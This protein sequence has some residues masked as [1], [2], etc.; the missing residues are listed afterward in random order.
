MQEKCQSYID[1]DYT[2]SLEIFFER[3]LQIF[4]PEDLKLFALYPLLPIYRA[5]FQKVFSTRNPRNKI[6]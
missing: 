1:L 3:V 2:S 5:D 6:H 4:T